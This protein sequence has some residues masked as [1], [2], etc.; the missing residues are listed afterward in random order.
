MHTPIHTHTYTY[1]YIYITQ[2]KIYAQYRDMLP[3]PRL[4]CQ[5]PGLKPK[6]RIPCIPDKS[7]RSLGSRSLYCSQ[8]LIRFI[9]Y[10]FLFYSSGCLVG[11]FTGLP[12]RT[13]PSA[14]VHCNQNEAGHQTIKSPS[15]PCWGAA[16]W[17]H[18][19]AFMP[20]DWWNW[21][22]KKMKSVSKRHF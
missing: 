15:M 11:N 8:I 18:S 13:L 20:Q 10:I 17:K 4:V 19:Q 6:G 9:A 21:Q 22:I 5:E 14:I 3:R 12:A 1:I 16:G 7:S 2:I